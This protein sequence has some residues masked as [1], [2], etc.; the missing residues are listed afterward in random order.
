MRNLAV[1]PARGGSKRIPGKN[2]K[3]FLGKPIIAYSIQAAL[4]SE[5]FDEVM[6]STDSEEIKSIA[7]K[8]GAKVPALRSEKNADDHA[9]ISD[10]MGEVLDYYSAENIHFDNVCC[11]FSTAPFVTPNRLI[12][13]LEKLQSGNFISVVPVQQYSFPI[14]RSL[15]I[16]EAQCLEMNWPEYAKTRSQDLPDSYHDAGQFYWAKLPEYNKQRRFYSEKAGYIVL[17]D[18]EA[19][20]IDTLEDWELA[21]LKYKIINRNG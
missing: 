1:I 13:G 19:H 10:M 8:Y 12:E 16:N 4:D 6:V 7:E 20:D 11:I 14:L 3:D 2:I 17:T 18:M 15:K 9:T 21:E 5:L